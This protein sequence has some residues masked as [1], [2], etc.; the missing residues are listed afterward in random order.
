MPQQWIDA[1]VHLFAARTTDK[2]AAPSLAATGTLH[3]V[4]TYDKVLKNNLPEGVVNVDF[5]GAK[6]SEH[7]I[8]ALEDL[9]RSG[10]PARGIVKASVDQPETLDWLSRPDIMGVRFY[11]KDSVPDLTTE[12]EKWHHLFNVLRHQG[13]HMLVYG[14]GDHLH[15]LIEQ[16]PED[17]PLLIDHL[18]MPHAENGYNDPHFRRLCQK[19]KHRDRTAGPVYFKG[20]GYRTSTVPE[21]ALPFLQAIIGEFGEDRLLLGASDAP[22]FGP[23][24][25]VSPGNSGKMFAE[26]MDYPRVLAYLDALIAALAEHTGLDADDLSAKLCRNNAKQLYRF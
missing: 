9:K 19:M 15:G 22:F 17:L 7:V 12:R 23:V 5:S 18:G 6:T 21:K 25:G 2:S 8:D 16:L 10:I 4:V 11:A 20:P 13:K 24:S 14:L 1:H 3:D 26:V